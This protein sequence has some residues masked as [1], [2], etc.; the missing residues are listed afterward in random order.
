MHFENKNGMNCHVLKDEYW[1]GKQLYLLTSG[2]K[3]IL[4][5]R[6]LLKF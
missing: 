4:F 6:V 3:E 2:L 1:E 5:Q